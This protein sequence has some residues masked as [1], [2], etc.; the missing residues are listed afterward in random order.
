MTR[1]RTGW[2]AMTALLGC[3]ARCSTSPPATATAPGTTPI[4]RP[5]REVLGNGVVLITQE[6]RAADVVALQ[7]WLR[8]GGRDEAPTELGLSHYLEHMLFKGTPR[9]GERRVGER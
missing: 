7:I 9:S 5:T 1:A 8:V 4:T 6:H 3:L 2:L